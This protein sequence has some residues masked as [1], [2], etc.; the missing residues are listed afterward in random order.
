MKNRAITFLFL[1]MV[2]SF[3]SAQNAGFYAPDTIC[4][5]NPL[6]ITDVLPLNAVSY[7]WNFCTGNASYEP[8]G[9]NMGNPI[10][11]LNAPHFITLVQDSLDF[12]TFT[13]STGNSSVIRCF[14]GTSLTQFPLNT[15]D[16]GSFGVLTNHVAGIQVKKDN[17]IWY[18]FV[19]DGNLLV[20]LVFGT[21][22]ANIPTAQIINL[23]NV[24]LASG[25]IIVHSNSQWVGFL[26]DFVGDSLFRL[27]FIPNLGSIPLVTNLK[28]IGQLN[29]PAS[30]TLAE[31]NSNWY[32]FICNKGNSTL[33]RIEFGASLTNPSPIGMALPN[34]SGLNQNA[35]ITLISDCGGVNGF[36]TNCV[37]QADQC[38][39]HLVFKS[40]LGGPVTG[41]QIENNGILNEPYGISEVLRDGGTL[42]AFVANYGSSSIT[43]MFFPSCTGVSHPFWTGFDPPP[44]IYADT[45]NYNILLTVNS[46]LPTES[47]SC[48]KIVVMPKPEL[49]LGPDRVVCQGSNTKLDAGI[50]NGTFLWSTGATTQ[51]ITVDTSGTYWVHVINTWN[52]EAVDTIKVTVNRTDSSM[53]DTTICKGLT[54]FAQNGQQSAAGI[55]HDTLQMA[56]GCD[57]IVTTHLKVKD[58]PLL[59]WFPNAFTPNGDGLNDFFRPVGANITR[60]KL[61]IFNRWG[62]MIFESKDISSGWNGYFKGSM[63]APD[64]YTFDATY[65]TSQF[66]GVVHHEKGTFTLTR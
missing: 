50:G 25:L 47:S 26:T 15:T 28:N 34:I 7:N 17:G 36:V 14:Y 60:Y 8:D 58:C 12:Y 59:I 27:D 22:L 32:A 46:G 16:L 57:S 23:P 1:W 55:Y 66:P 4:L 2:S 19:A 20:R 45:G 42:Y 62:I 44:V 61:Q 37:V 24:S 51:S 65:E 21:S 63:A 3:C 38:V 31:E 10:Q 39:I 5:G 49:S 52:C 54:Y 18:G 56:T 11:K 6:L 13:T 30:I 48:K 41:Y 9:I 43:R 64:V 29:S 35:G 53:V 33:S 40:G